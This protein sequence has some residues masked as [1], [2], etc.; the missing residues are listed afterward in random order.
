MP[1]FTLTCLDN[2]NVLELRMATRADHLAYVATFGSAVKLA[3]PLLD[4]VDGNP[5]GSFFVLD[6]D[7]EA[8]AEAFAAGDPYQTAGVFGERTIHAFRQVIG[9]L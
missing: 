4:K 8:T 7:S 3:G 5:K 9:S 1:F 6:I 2:A